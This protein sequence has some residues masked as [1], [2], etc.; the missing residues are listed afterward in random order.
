MV[1]YGNG[2]GE[3][4]GKAAGSHGGGGGSVDMGA[5]LGQMVTDTANTI[6]A[7]PPGALLLLVVG[8]VVGL[9]VVKRAL[10]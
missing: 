9:W 5:Q 10:F 8:I 6:S 7:L 4:A 2:I 3:G 1:E